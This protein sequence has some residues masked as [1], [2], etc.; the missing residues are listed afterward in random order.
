MIKQIF[1]QCF[2]QILE[3]HRPTGP[4]QQRSGNSDGNTSSPVHVSNVQN[5]RNRQYSASTSTFTLA[6]LQ[7]IFQ[8]IFQWIFPPARRSCWVI[9]RKQEINNSNKCCSQT[10]QSSNPAIKLL[11][12]ISDVLWSHI[13]C[14]LS[15]DGC[16]VR[17]ITRSRDNGNL[18]Q[19]LYPS[20]LYVVHAITGTI[21]L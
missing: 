15:R 1:Q 5:T 12:A 16:L 11:F 18:S 10:F 19:A 17:R 20:S 7:Q 4:L 21:L 2:H 14:Q 3:Y 13:R 8:Q 9:S 6:I